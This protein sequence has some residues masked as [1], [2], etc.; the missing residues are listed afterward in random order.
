MTRLGLWNQGFPWFIQISAYI[1]LSI[2]LAWLMQMISI[3]HHTTGI[4]DSEK[5]VCFSLESVLFLILLVFSSFRYVRI[6]NFQFMGYTNFFNVGGIDTLAYKDFFESAE[7]YS[8][9]EYIHKIPMEKLYAA[10]FWMFYHLDL[11]FELVLCFNYT[12]IF[13][14][15]IKFCKVFK[16]EANCFLSLLSLLIIIFQSYNTLRWSTSLLLSIWVIDAL[17]NNKV[18]KAL[19]FTLFFSI[20]F[21]TGSFSLFVPVF[22]FIFSKNLSRKRIAFLYLIIVLLGCLAVYSFPFEKL[23]GNSRL[24]VHIYSGS[25]KPLGWIVIYLFYLFNILLTRK[26]YFDSRFRLTLFYICICLMPLCLLEMKMKMMYRFSFFGHVIMYFG[27]VELLKTNKHIKIGIILNGII[28]LLL[29]LNI[30][31]FYGNDIISCGVPYL[32]GTF[33]L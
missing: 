26:T 1:F 10:I 24:I 31:V 11:G 19:L 7:G 23:F 33:G 3:A 25:E 27:L 9:D 20:G 17:L 15:L 29:L 6:N 22:G 30:L 5:S 14:C 32:F 28:Y 12:L 4:S 8:L 18:Y 13:L 21:H 2:T 16:L